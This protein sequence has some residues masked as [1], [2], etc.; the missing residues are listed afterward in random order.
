MARSVE[1]RVLLFICLLCALFIGGVHAWL[2]LLRL[3]SSAT[4]YVNRLGSE[5]AAPA[6][7]SGSLRAPNDGAVGVPDGTGPR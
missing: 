4:V 6:P 5:L 1:S 3:H 7:S 2:L